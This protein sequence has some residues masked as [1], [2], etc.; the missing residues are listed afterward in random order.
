M[1]VFEKPELAEAAL[2]EKGAQVSRDGMRLVVTVS[3]ADPCQVVLGVL[4]ETRSGVRVLR[5]TVTTLEDVYLEQDH[6]AT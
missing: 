6:G 2:R 3:G 1:E 5:P 4:S